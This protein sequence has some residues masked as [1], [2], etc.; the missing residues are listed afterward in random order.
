MQ[1]CDRMA[2]NLKNANI[3]RYEC[4]YGKYH[5]VPSTDNF[6]PLSSSNVVYEVTCPGCGKTYISA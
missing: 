2:Q 6:P 4:A 5:A 1:F 3:D